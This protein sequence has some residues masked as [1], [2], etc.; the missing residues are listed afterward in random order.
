MGTTTRF[1]LP[2]RELTDAPDLPTATKGLADGVE[3]WLARAIPCTSTTRPG[4]APQGLTIYE[5]DTGAFLLWS[6]TAWIA[7][8]AATS[9]TVT[10]EARYGASSA[11]TIP[12]SALT[13]VAFG[14]APEATSP[15]VTRSV[16]GV[17]HL[18]TLGLT[19]RW[20]VDLSVRFAANA[21]AGERYAGLYLSSATSVPLVGNGGDGP[22]AVTCHAFTARRFT[23]GQ[24]LLV[25]AWQDSGAGRQL[26]P[27]TSGLGN[28]RLNLTYL[29]A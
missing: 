6:G 25:Q 8:P 9:S 19:G 11:Q 23:S 2:Y 3:G 10:A 1:G 12:S 28:V 26:E 5:T 18:F 16:T 17:G 24:A 27:A 15:N 14:A 7:P 21:A 22:A 20:G 13:P 29:G 4:S